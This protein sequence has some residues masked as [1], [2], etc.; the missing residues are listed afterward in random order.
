MCKKSKRL[1]DVTKPKKS[2]KDRYIF[3]WGAVNIILDIIICIGVVISFLEG[4]K[5]A[6]CIIV[7]VGVVLAVIVN[8]A[9]DIYYKRYKKN[10][11]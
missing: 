6:L 9:A 7:I 1:P 2:L 4:S 10:K 5:L 11:E 3:T 8:E